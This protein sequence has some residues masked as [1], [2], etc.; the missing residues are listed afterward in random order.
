MGSRAHLLAGLR[1]GGPRASSPFENDVHPFE[2]PYLS[3]S[4]PSGGPTLKANAAPFTPGGRSPSQGSHMLDPMQE[5]EGQFAA[6]RMQQALAS[7]ASNAQP[8]LAAMYGASRGQ[9]NGQEVHQ[10]Q[11]SLDYQAHMQA[12]EMEN[13]IRH[14]QAQLLQNQILQQQ[15][16]QVQMEALRLQTANH[17]Q[18]QQQQQ[19]VAAQQRLV[20][21]QVQSELDMQAQQQDQANQHVYSAHEQR[22]AAQ[23]SIQASLRQRQVSQMYAQLLRQHQLQQ[24]MAQEVTLENRQQEALLQRLHYLR[25]LQQGA[26]PLPGEALGD[27]PPPSS[28]PPARSASPAQMQFNNRRERQPSNNA[29][30]VAVSW[31]STSS[32]LNNNRHSQARTPP[33]IVVDDSGS[34]KSDSGTH[35]SASESMET[36]ET[37]AEDVGG[38]V[39]PKMAGM[40]ALGVKK[41]APLP[42]AAPRAIS[43][44]ATP[45]SRAFSS[46]RALNSTTS[47][48]SGSPSATGAPQPSRQPRGPPTE[49]HAVNFSAR[50]S[51]RTRR[52]AMSKLCASPRAASFTMGPRSSIVA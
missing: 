48:G 13:M 12:Q 38:A 26:L 19:Q 49:F 42:L 3:N 44:S 2:Q 41:P 16:Q 30:D 37:S 34:E 17:H 15:Q 1:T 27:S 25:Q 20:L 18:Q 43:L 24:N 45:R 11:Q 10:S 32:S 33:S 47:S 22:Q 51:A 46:D 35:S 7:A 6:L 31:R 36:P 4:P 52:E 28:R 40:A 21:A 23:A 9:P 5:I 29:A 39:K 8:Q 50:L 14:K